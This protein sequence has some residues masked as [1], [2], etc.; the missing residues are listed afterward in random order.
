MKN[1]IFIPFAHDDS[2]KSGVNFFN[3]KISSNK[4]MLVYMKNVSVALVSAKRYNPEVECALV[5][6]LSDEE[7]PAE[8][9]EIFTRESIKIFHF[10][11]DEFRF[12]NNMPW[13][14][15]F[16]KLCAL[17]HVLRETDYENFL[18]LDSDV[19]IQAS[20]KS[21]WQELQENILLYDINEGLNNPSFLGVLEEVRKFYH[22]KKFITWYGGEFVAASREN[23][24][25]FINE[26]RKVFNV[27]K[28]SGETKQYQAAMKK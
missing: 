26:A 3:K 27:I 13:G 22:D 28:D 12:D 1:L 16:Y 21:I 23:A 24:E 14:L 8:F 4:R 7:I 19:Y 18:Y 10:S 25:N 17:S 20:L 9:H 11:F 2:M 5:T 6:N 15:A